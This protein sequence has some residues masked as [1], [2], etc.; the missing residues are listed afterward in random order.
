MLVRLHVPQAVERKERPALGQR[1][2]VL[3]DRIGVRVADDDPPRIDALLLQDVQL[4][5]PDRGVQRVGGDRDP[6]PPVRP[7]HR[8]EDPLLDRGDPGEVGADLAQ[9]ARPD[10]GAVDPLRDVALELLRDLVG[11][12]PPEPALVV[13]LAVPAGPEDDLEPTRCAI[14]RIAERV[15]R[16][17]D[18]VVVAP[19]APRRLVHQ[20]HAAGLLV[21]G[22]LP[23]RELGIV[24]HAVA[25]EHVAGEIQED[26]LVNQR[27]PR[28]RAATGPVTVM[29]DAIAPPLPGDRRRGRGGPV[30]LLV[31]AGE[32]HARDHGRPST[33]DT[34]A[35]RS[36]SRSAAASTA[37]N[38]S[39]LA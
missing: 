22:E 36:P 12:R 33:T 13:R 26:V 27:E 4:V 35:T 25:P 20:R 24:Q 16:R 28:S 21:E 10:V 32:K 9:E 15:L 30:R 2:V 11:L 14:S 31:P 19:E 6:R 37:K 23:V 34:I 8:A 5:E 3:V 7:R 29:T 1:H 17:R 38:D 18:V 39:M